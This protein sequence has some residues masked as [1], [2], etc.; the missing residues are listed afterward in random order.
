LP[1]QAL[2][3]VIALVGNGRRVHVRQ[4]TARHARLER[5]EAVA[6]HIECV[7]TARAA[8]GSA[9]RQRFAA[10]TGAKVHHHLAPVGVH[11]QGQELRAFVLHFDGTPGEG[12]GFLQG[13][14]A[15]QAQ[16]PRRIRRGLGGDA[17]LRQLFLDLAALGIEHVHPQV[18]AY[19]VAAGVRPAPR[20]R[21][22]IGPARLAPSTRANCGGAGPS[23]RRRES[24][25][26]WPATFFSV[27]FRAEAKK[28]RGPKKPKIA[29]LRSLA[30]EPER[31]SCSNSSFLR[32]TAKAVSAK[33]ARSRGPKAAV[34]TEI[35]RHDSVGGMFK[36]EN[37][38][39]QIGAGV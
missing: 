20:S 29:S 12:I 38:P 13:R 31:A 3:A 2:D 23:G 11:Q 28:S 22:P 18:Q 8:H 17:C 37:Q 5:I 26:K 19:P 33:V 36:L 39:D 10:R 4:A 1:G 35:A 6:G 9:Q 34:F 30:P 7:Q 21:R 14:L 27:S 25:R 32:N 15:L 24:R 16:T